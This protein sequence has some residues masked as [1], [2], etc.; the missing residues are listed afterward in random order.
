MKRMNSDKWLITEMFEDTP[1]NLQKKEGIDR[2]DKKKCL[3]FH[4]LLQEPR[5]SLKLQQ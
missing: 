5:K 2:G 4:Q 3:H 1:G